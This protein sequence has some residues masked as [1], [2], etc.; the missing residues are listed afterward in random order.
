MSWEEVRQYTLDY[1]NHE[2]IS[3]ID[4]CAQLNVPFR[5]INYSYIF[6]NADLKGTFALDFKKA[7][8]EW[9][10]TKMFKDPIVSSDLQVVEF[11]EKNKELFIQLGEFNDMYVISLRQSPLVLFSLWE[12][13]DNDKFKQIVNDYF[14]STDTYTKYECK[15]A[16]ERLFD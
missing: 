11:L 3:L 15:I 7:L 16:W 12:K 14:I 4:I 13:C 2:N 9:Y 5:C 10:H 8:T 6:G 1:M